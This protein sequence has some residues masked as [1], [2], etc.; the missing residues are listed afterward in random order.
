MPMLGS[1]CRAIDSA[2]GIFIGDDIKKKGEINKIFALCDQ[3]DEHYNRKISNFKDHNL[4]LDYYTYDNFDMYMFN[5]P[6]ELFYDYE[7]FKEGKYSNFS[8]PYK[9]HIRKFYI[10]RSG[11]Y[12]ILKSENYRT[13]KENLMP[14]RNY[15]EQVLIKSEKLHSTLENILNVNIPI[16]LEL[17]DKPELEN[18]IFSQKHLK[19]ILNLEAI[20]QW[21]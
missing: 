4:L 8:E 21:I 1:D 7:M 5:V 14:Y 17:V 16:D 18:E 20:D 12:P 10:I 13:L 15:I 9:N 2:V 11:N 6:N 19:K 3:N